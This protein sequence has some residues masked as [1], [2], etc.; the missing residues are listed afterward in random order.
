MNNI[1]AERA[2]LQL[3]KEEIAKKLGISTR[4][5]HNYTHGKPIPSTVLIKMSEMF[6]CSVD[7]LLSTNIS[8]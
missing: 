4:T 6:N 5:Y 1:E 3:T 2:R 8:A 7:Y